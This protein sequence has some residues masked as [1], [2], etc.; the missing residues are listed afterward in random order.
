MTAPLW[1]PSPERVS[2]SRIT[3]L[4]RHLE[5]RWD[6]ALKDYEALHSFSVL[7]PDA[8][9]L[10]VWEFCGVIGDP[11]DRVVSGL[12]RMPGARFFP[13]SRLNFTENILRR[14]DG[15]VAMIAGGEGK[16][17]RALT[18]AELTASVEQC[19]KA[20]SAAGIRPGDRVA[21]YLPNIPEAMIAALGAAAIGAIWSSCSPDF[22]V[23]GVLDRF[24]Q[25]EPR[26]LVT[27]DGYYYG[28]KTH[29]TL[30][31]AAAIA[32]DLPSLERTVI[33]PYVDDSTDAGAVRNGC[34]WQEFQKSA[35]PG[36]LAFER[37]PF[38]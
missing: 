24:G 5:R 33:V 27:V 30:D 32:R 19:A 23:Q 18:W 7:C 16:D 4:R 3:A 11:G 22:G 35:A 21:G 15:R 29:R 8:F 38:D 31:R 10:A 12:G 1:T 26:V 2:L 6:V 17:D 14:R 36:P 9:W 28:G 37:F 20:L 25:I 34:L 13:G